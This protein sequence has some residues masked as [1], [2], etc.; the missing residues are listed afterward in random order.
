MVVIAEVPEA[1][2]HRPDLRG[3]RIIALAVPAQHELGL[4]L[5][6]LETGHGRAT[7]DVS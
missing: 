6:V 5:E 7:V 2:Q 4:L 1:R 3:H